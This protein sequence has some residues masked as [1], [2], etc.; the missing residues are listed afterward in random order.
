[1]VRSSSDP[2]Q[3]APAIRSEVRAL[4]DGVTVSQVQTMEEAVADSTAQPRFYVLLLGTFAAVALCLAA[5]GIYGVMSYS[6]ARRTHEI[7]VR[8]ALGA[9]RSD[10]LKLVTGQAMILALGGAAAGLAGALPLTHVMASLL[11]G[12]RVADP[13]TFAVVSALLAAVAVLASYVPARRAAKVDPM[14][15]LRYE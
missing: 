13:V 9:K 12:V 2:A 4:D 14:V 10:V 8:M 11:Y 1:V 5:V 7:G 15:A 3:L 6:V